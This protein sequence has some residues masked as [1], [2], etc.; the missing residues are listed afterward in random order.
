VVEVSRQ[1]RR[2]R[3]NFFMAISLVA[4]ENRWMSFAS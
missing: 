3:I 1:T 2:V 4:V